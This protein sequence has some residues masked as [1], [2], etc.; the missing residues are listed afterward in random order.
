MLQSLEGYSILCAFVIV[1]V[2]SSMANV[3]LR[4]PWKRTD[5]SK[6]NCANFVKICCKPWVH[7][8]LLKLSSYRVSL[9]ALELALDLEAFGLVLNE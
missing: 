4:G 1:I 2:K 5:V 8:L 9:H 6:P 3:R 7:I